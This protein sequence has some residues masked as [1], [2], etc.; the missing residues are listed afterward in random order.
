M[1]I[2][3]ICKFTDV[4]GEEVGF[5]IDIKHREGEGYWYELYAIAEEGRKYREFIC[6]CHEF[7]QKFTD[8]VVKACEKIIDHLDPQ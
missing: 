2:E 3:L 6:I 7:T 8:C 4:M 1:Y 5:S